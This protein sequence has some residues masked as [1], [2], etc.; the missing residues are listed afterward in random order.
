MA[1]DLDAVA[2]HDPDPVEDEHRDAAVLVGVVER[3][4]PHLLFTRRADHLGEHPGQMSFPGGAREPEDTDIVGT[5]IRET[6][7]EIGA[8]PEEITVI[9]RLDDIRTVSRYAVTPV[10]GRLVDRE[11]HPDE[12]EVA[13]IAVL[14]VE[15]FFDPANYEVEV[16]SHPAEGERPV[17]YFH[18]AGYTI[19]GATARVLVALFEVAA[20]WRPP[21]AR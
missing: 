6:G 2:A 17:H 10:V 13:G 14:P 3:G 8:H 7:E 18:V 19:W 16:R 20:D 4:R 21:S 9:G 5:A 12:R 1:L 15:P 11:Y